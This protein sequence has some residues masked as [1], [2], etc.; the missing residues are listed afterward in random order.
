MIL[1]R[2]SEALFLVQRL[3]DEAHRFA[4]TYHRSKRGR[5]MQASALDGIPGLGPSRRRALLD[6]FVTVS[7]IR[8]ASE[9]E[10]VEVDGI[11][12][13]LAAQIALALRSEEGSAAEPDGGTVVEDAALG[14]AVDT[15]TGEIIDR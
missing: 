14:V 12:P 2:T 13:A 15:A 7:A 9:E 3:Q 10:L 6:R 8:A 5:A 11:G 4:I 1:P